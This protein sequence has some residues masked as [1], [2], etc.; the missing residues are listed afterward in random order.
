M[1]F[2][3]P[4]HLTVVGGGGVVVGGNGG[5]GGGNGGNGGSNGGNAVSYLILVAPMMAG[6]NN[7]GW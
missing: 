2:H 5:N 4:P 6:N 1:P 3:L 7:D